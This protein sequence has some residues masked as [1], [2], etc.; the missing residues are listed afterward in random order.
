MSQNN[1]VWPLS[2]DKRGQIQKE[3]DKNTSTEAPTEEAPEE[4]SSEE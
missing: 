1:S 2:E 4:E 3:D